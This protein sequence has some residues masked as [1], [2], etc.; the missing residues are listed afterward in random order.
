[1]E[2]FEFLRDVTI[3]QYLPTGSLIHRLDPRVRLVG[4]AIL[5]LAVILALHPAGLIL[6]MLIF[7]SGL[8]LARIPLRFA[9]RGLLPPLPFIIILAGLQVFINPYP[10]TLPIY[11]RIGALVISS[12]DLWA[13]VA[14]ILRFTGLVLGISLVSYCLST[15]EM[16]YGLGALL[17]PLARLGLPVHDLVMMIQIT[18]RFLPL[19]AQSME[20]IAKAQASRGADWGQGRGG[21][22]KRIRRVIP[23]LVPLF[24]V[25]LRRA[26]QMALAMD[27]RAYGIRANRTAMIEMHFRWRDGLALAIAILVSGLIA[28]L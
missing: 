21:L 5:L 24:L 26:E 19:L 1:M 6:G 27:A 20:R 13:G 4:G 23:L 9:L 28:W 10:D 2:S 11:G 18:L 3:G 25:S 12:I 7:L 17:R 16:I 8:V 14:L 22:L 15:T